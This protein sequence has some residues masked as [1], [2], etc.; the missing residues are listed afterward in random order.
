MRPPFS[1]SQITTLAATFEADLRAYAAAG[2]DGIGIWEIKLQ[3]GGDD[4]ALEQL[5]AS[6]LGR[7]AAVPS[8][9]SILPLPLMDGPAEPRER[10]DAICASVHRLARFEPSSVVCLTGPGDDR[11]TVVEGLRVIGDEAAR[12]GVRIGLEPINRIGGEDW[13]SISS[14]QEAAELLDA[15]DRPAL[16]IQFDSWHVWDT[17]DV[18]DEIERHAHRFVGVHIADWR[19]PTRGWADRVLPGDGVADLPGLLRTLE[20]A[21][22]DG[23]Y[24]LEIFSDNGTFGNAWP[25]SLW[26]VPEEELARRGK[27]AF[28]RAWSARNRT[29]LDQVS[30]GAV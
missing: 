6:G 8:V 18:V 12:A 22:W 5:E 19:D 14:L 2:V 16:G 28:E 4:Q 26:D 27:E 13:T 21:G 15:A 29:P 3:E 17:A 7:A 24:D 1:I 23:F 30:P 10:I 9:P 20:R 11:D 25:G